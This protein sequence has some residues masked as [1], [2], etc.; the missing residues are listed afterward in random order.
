MVILLQGKLIKAN[1]G[2][3]LNIDIYR[4]YERLLKETSYLI[5]LRSYILIFS[6]SFGDFSKCTSNLKY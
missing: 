1:G 2:F 4:F 3:M 6:W 5:F